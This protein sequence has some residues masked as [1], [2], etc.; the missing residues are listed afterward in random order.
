LPELA[1]DAFERGFK[2][3]EIE[4]ELGEKE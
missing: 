2:A 4:D 3:R 1:S